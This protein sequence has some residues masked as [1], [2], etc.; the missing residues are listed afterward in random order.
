MADQRQHH[1]VVVYELIKEHDDRVRISATSWGIYA[2]RNGL[3]PLGARDASTGLSF[4]FPRPELGL[5]H[6][7]KTPVFDS[8]VPI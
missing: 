8:I 6:P 7:P 2:G 3:I 4:D 5:R 1:V